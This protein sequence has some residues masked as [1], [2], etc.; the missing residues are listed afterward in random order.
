MKL[1]IWLLGGLWFVLSEPAVAQRQRTTKWESGMVEKNQKTGVWEYYSYAANGQQLLMQKYD[2]STG[3]LLYFRPDGKE[4]TAEI[5][6]NQWVK[7]LLD[8]P[9]WCVG[10]YEALI[11]FMTELKYPAQAQAH[12]VQGRV[13]VSFVIDTLGAVS[14]H[15]VVQG[16]GY[17]CDEEALR[18]AQ[19]TPAEW[20]PGRIGSRAVPVVYE[21]PFTFRLK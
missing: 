16:I 2:H 12:D 18:V 4:Y 7:T 6:P 5:A 17:G 10:G 15:K 11:S 8:Q 19:S 14:G 1:S 20:V 9:P 13:V 3:K 21:L